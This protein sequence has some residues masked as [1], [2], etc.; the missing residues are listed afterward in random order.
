MMQDDNAQSTTV[1]LSKKDFSRLREFI[2]KECGINIVDSK[3]TMLEAR[4]QKRLRKLDLTSFSQY[5]DYLFSPHGIDEELTDMINQVTTNK[6]DFFR[7]PGHFDHLRRKVLPEL[8][9]TGGTIAAWSAG[10]S[11]GEEPYTLAMVFKEFGC[12]FVILATD[13]STRV[14]DKAK[15]AVYDEER[16]DPISPELRRK[17]LLASK[18]RA[19]RL[20]RIAPELR[21]HVKFRRLNFMDGDFGFREPIDII[22]CRNVIIYFDKPTQERLLNKFCQ[23]LSPHGYL[24]MGHSETLFGMNVPLAQAAPTIYRKAI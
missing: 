9:R 10:C 5:C 4:L 13:I 22:F 11:T 8:A 19:K 21:E 20:Y 23:Y 14:L 24:F 18:D 3:K 6:T 12:N 2:Y 15:L 1:T 16:I 7:E 17:Y